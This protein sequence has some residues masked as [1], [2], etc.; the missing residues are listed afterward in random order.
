MGVYC[1]Q[2]KWKQEVSA[3]IRTMQCCCSMCCMDFGHVMLID[4][5]RIPIDG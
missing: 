4:C 2:F 3:M 1:G 5:N